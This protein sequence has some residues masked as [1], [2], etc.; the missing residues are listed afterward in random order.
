M[1]AAIVFGGSGFIGTH[2][3][4]RLVTLSSEPVLSADIRDPKSA[5]PGVDYRR[6]DVRDLHDFSASMPVSTIF[7][8]AAVHITPGHPD[9]EYYETNVLGALEVTALAR[10]CDAREIVFTSSIAVYGPGDETKS[11][12]SSLAPVSP[13]GRSKMMAERIHRVWFDEQPGRR[14]VIARPAAI[15]GPGEGGNF[16]RMAKLLKAGMFIYPGR[17]NAV[18]ACFYVDDL[19]DA[20]MFARVSP[21]RFVLFNACY[22]DRYTLE[23]IVEA[24]RARHFP[25][26]KTVAIPLGLLVAA[27]RA[28]RPISAMGLGIHPERVMKLVRSTDIAPGWLATH[29]ASTPGRIASALERWADRSRGSFT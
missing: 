26:A 15:F 6:G 4:R 2:L 17:R 29:E 22:P 18:K 23:Q 27:A 25:K 9:H 20:I 8:L 19:L 12:T 5:V 10:R 14:L 7:N 1:G 24:F 11:E 21:D 16:T 3:L 13:Y 28:L